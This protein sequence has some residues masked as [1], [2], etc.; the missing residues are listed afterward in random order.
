MADA[1]LWIEAERARFEAEREARR[2]VTLAH[3]I[4]V[5]RGQKKL[6]PLRHYL[7]T[8]AQ[9]LTDEEMERRKRE[10]EDIVRSMG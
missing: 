6:K 4:A 1:D 3:A 2:D 5:F 8:E 10:Y 7:R 9:K